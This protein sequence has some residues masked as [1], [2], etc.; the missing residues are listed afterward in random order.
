MGFGFIP[1]RAFFFKNR[2]PERIAAAPPGRGAAAKKPSGW[3]GL[4]LERAQ[5]IGFSF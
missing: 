2:C 3:E 1:V 5:R 4:K